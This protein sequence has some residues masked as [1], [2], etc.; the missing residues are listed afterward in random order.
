MIAL[1]LLVV[2]VVKFWLLLV[3]LA[4]AL[5]LGRVIGCWLARRDDRAIERR[6]RDAE[7]CERADRQHAAML[8][9]DKLVGVYGDWPPLADDRIETA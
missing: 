3:T 6:R 9:G 5:V 4:G 7:I 2:F 1:T 8:V